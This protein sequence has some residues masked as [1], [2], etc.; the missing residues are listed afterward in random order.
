MENII[1]YPMKNTIFW[2]ML[3]GSHY[4][5]KKWKRRNRKHSP[6]STRP[7]SSRETLEKESFLS[8]IWTADFQQKLSAAV[9]GNTGRTWHHTT[10]LLTWRKVKQRPRGIPVPGQRGDIST[11]YTLVWYI[12]R[13]S[14]RDSDWK[15]F[16]R[17]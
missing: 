2:S 15:Y 13:S 5:C 3:F 7:G 12:A 6:L 17:V 4:T 8:Y 16:N 1:Y 10:A 11:G 14:I 9:N